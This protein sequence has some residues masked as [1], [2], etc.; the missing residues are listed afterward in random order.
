MKQDGVARRLQLVPNE[1]ELPEDPSDGDDHGKPVYNV[2]SGDPGP[3][4]ESPESTDSHD[5]LDA[6]KVVGTAVSYAAMSWVACCMERPGIEVNVA[7]VGAG[8]FDA[9][10]LLQGGGSQWLRVTLILEY[11]PRLRTLVE[12]IHP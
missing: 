9:E 4:P 12:P 8:I 6:S 7:Q 2:D 3:M 5:K 10:V 11:G 1:P